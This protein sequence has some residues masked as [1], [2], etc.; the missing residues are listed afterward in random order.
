MNGDVLTQAIYNLASM[1]AINPNAMSAKGEIEKI[2]REYNK[3]CLE[4]ISAG[5]VLFEVIDE[6][7]CTQR[8]V[9]AA[10]E[11]VSKDVRSPKVVRDGV[12]KN[13]END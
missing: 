13:E 12:L 5:E 11:E 9:D 8:V 10:M 4:K 3:L 2:V 7:P 6:K 1:G